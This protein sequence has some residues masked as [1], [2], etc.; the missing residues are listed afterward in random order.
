MKR[1]TDMIEA[2]LTG[3]HKKCIKFCGGVRDKKI[4]NIGCYNGWFEKF[5]VEN[6]CMEVIGI[7]TDENNL[8]NAKFQVKDKRV[9]FLKAS[10]LDLSQFGTNYFDLVTMFDVLEHIPKNREKEALAEI[11]RVLGERGEFYLSTPHST[12]WSCVLDPA[13]WLVGHRHYSLKQFKRMAKKT[14][15]KIEKVECGGGFWELH[16]MILLY[17]FKWFF[18]SEIPFKNWFEKKRDV[19]FLRENGWTNIFVKLRKT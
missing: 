4:L 8:Q 19:E 10:A 3:R 1:Y 18:R 9:K 7:D 14:G 12:F 11:K 2:R 15:F 17:I 13:W 16:S 6:N 5:A